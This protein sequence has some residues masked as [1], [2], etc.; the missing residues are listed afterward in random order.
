MIAISFNF[1]ISWRTL[2]SCREASWF[3]FWLNIIRFVN[4]KDESLG[5]FV[6]GIESQK[7]VWN[8]GQK[9]GSLGRRK[10]M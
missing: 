3:E 6:A 2:C 9:A 8:F 4:I 1:C 5:I 7:Y 10:R